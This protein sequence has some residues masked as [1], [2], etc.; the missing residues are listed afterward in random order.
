MLGYIISIIICAIFVLL[1]KKMYD[2]RRR[3]QKLLY[4][5]GKYLQQ[6]KILR[7][8]LADR[9]KVLEAMVDKLAFDNKELAR[10]NEMKSKFMSI[11]AHDLKQPLTSIQGYTSILNNDTLGKEDQK[12]INSILKAAT[13]MNHL[14]SDLVDASMIES[15]SFQISSQE[16]NY[17]ELIDEVY[18]QYKVLADTKNIIFRKIDIPLAIQIKADKFRINQVISNLI[19]N[20]FKFT[21]EGGIVEIRYCVEDVYLKTVVSDNGA[22]IDTFDRMKIFE[23]FQQAQNLDEEHKKMGWGLGL[24]IASDIINAHK[25]SIGVDSAGPGKGSSFWFL[26]PLK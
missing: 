17:N 22:G 21:P 6:I 5:Q 7:S 26:L 1:V 9:V 3:A 16:F 10:L 20:A 14:M 11:V 8:Q 19:N 13:N 15:G 18:T 24:A 2:F 25:G 23:K 4:S 12:I